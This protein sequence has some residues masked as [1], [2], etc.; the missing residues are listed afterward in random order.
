MRQLILEHR[1]V[2][3]TFRTTAGNLFLMICCNGMHMA[4]RIWRSHAHRFDR[5][6]AGQHFS[7]LVNALPEIAFLKKAEPVK[8]LSSSIRIDSARKGL[9]ARKGLCPN[10]THSA[11]NQRSQLP[12]SEAIIYCVTAEQPSRPQ[13]K[14]LSLRTCALSQPN[15]CQRC[16]IQPMEPNHRA[17]THSSE[18]AAGKGCQRIPP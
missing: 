2:N 6:P 5:F 14:L 9:E 8:P 15:T 17:P 11:L 16:A 10:E 18:Q 12:I 13:R 7:N 3:R 4:C 1:R